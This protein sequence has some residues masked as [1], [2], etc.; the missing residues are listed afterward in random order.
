[1]SEEEEPIEECGGEGEGEGGES[2]KEEEIV[3]EPKKVEAPLPVPYPI[4]RVDPLTA[5]MNLNK[6]LDFLGTQ[7]NYTCTMLKYGDYGKG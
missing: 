6:E 4:W 2:E 1:M 3:E 7:I 5:V